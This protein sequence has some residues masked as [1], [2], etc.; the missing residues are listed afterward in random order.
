MLRNLIAIPVIFLTVMLQSALISHVPLLSGYADLPLVM[1][2][3]W[4]IQDQVD[5][6]YH[7]AV[8]TGVLVGFISG[9]TWI[10]PLITYLLVV[11]MA[12][13]FQRRVW[14]APLL[15]MFSVAFIGSIVLYTLSFLALSVSGTLLPV[16]DVVGL[17][18]LPGTLLNMLLVI[19]VYIVMR[20]LARWAYPASEV[21]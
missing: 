11:A 6:A 8:A 19:P 20:D 21:E 15:A 7:W 13:A 2:A 14:Q 5:T 1:L 4:A 18:A 16:T 9:L 17:L 3:A 10:V 12:R